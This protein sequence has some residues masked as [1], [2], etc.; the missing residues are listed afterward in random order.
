MPD[1]LL[2]VD[3]Y[4]TSRG[5]AGYDAKYDL[6]GNGTIGIPDFLIF[7]DNYGNRVPPSGD[8]G[9]DDHSNTLMRPVFLWTVRTQDRSKRVV[10][11]ISSVCRSVSPGR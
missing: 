1:F 4:G 2:F 9:S 3:H 5:D 11:S 8:G 10:M 7:V 6:D